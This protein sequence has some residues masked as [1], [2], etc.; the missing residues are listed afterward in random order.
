MGFNIVLPT[1]W[2]VLNTP[3]QAVEDSDIERYISESYRPLT[4]PDGQHDW[5]VMEPYSVVFRLVQGQREVWAETTLNHFSRKANGIRI[6][7][8]DD[9][10]HGDSTYYY[11]DMCGF[12]TRRIKGAS[13]TPKI[14]FGNATQVTMCRDDNTVRSRSND[15]GCNAPNGNSQRP[16]CINATSSHRCA[17]DVIQEIA[18]FTSWP[19]V[20]H[21]DV[22]EEKESSAEMGAEGLATIG[23]SRRRQSATSGV[24]LGTAQEPM[25]AIVRAGS[26][27]DAEAP[28]D[29]RAHLQMHVKVGVIRQ[30]G[31]GTNGN[32]GK[33]S[34]QL[35]DLKR[36][37]GNKLLVLRQPRLETPSMYP[38]IDWP[39]TSDNI[40]AL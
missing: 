35:L 23:A 30:M 38:E 6:K 27:E 28:C 16:S 4:S 37:S 7:G 17:P 32:N 18:T 25:T 5:T 21:T 15:Q 26:Y 40:C 20:K 11:G 14:R 3:I 1:T 19:I 2:F 8:Y 33:G 13:P 36:M 31:T 22:A 39:C 29:I 9:L 24:A 12:L 10:K 34:L